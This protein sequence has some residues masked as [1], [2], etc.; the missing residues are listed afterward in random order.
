MLGR[1]QLEQPPGD[2]KHPC[3]E[4]QPNSNG[5]IDH[6]VG[7][8]VAATQ[9]CSTRASLSNACGHD[10]GH[11]AKEQPT[12]AFVLVGLAIQSTGRWST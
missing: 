1:F 11:D 8:G 10:S 3:S 2:E 5:S 6:V 7:A 4:E 9:R 12:Q